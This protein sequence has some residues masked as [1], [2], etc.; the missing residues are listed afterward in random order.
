[1][2]RGN[3]GSRRKHR[4]RFVSPRTNQQAV[5]NPQC[6]KNAS[7]VSPAQ[8]ALIR[9]ER[10]EAICHSCFCLASTPSY[11]HQKMFSGGKSRL[12]HCVV[13]LLSRDNRERRGKV[14]H[15]FLYRIHLAHKEAQVV[16]ICK[17]HRRSRRRSRR[18]NRRRSRHRHQGSFWFFLGRKGASHTMKTANELSHTHAHTE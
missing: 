12:I 16:F 1:M 6:A 18:R 10:E 5:S 15:T 14:S 3:Y 17:F 13:G 2:T 8:K 4:S 7:F 11:V 9:R